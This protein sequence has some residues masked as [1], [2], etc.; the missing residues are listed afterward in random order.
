MIAIAFYLLKVIICS[1]ILYGY[2]HLA[3]KDKVFHQWNRFYLLSIVP[4]SI[5]LPLLNLHIIAPATDGSSMV[6]VMQI[7]AGADE[8]VA[9]RQAPMNPSIALSSILWLLYIAG[10][11]AVAAVFA[12]ALVSIRKMI[13]RNQQVNMGDFTFLNTRE[14]GTPFS[15]FRYLLWN[16]EIPLDSEN[17]RRILDHELIHIREHHSRDKLFILCVLVVGWMN[18][19]FWLIRRELGLIHEFIADQK[20]VGRGNAQALAKLLLE[21]SFPGYAPMMTN[22]FFTSSIKRRIAMMTKKQHPALNYLSRLMM[23]P[24][25]FVL[26]FAFGVKAETFLNENQ[27]TIHLDKPVTVVIDAGHGGTDDGAMFENVSEKN[28]TLAFAQV[29]KRLNNNP[30]LKLVFTRE[31]DVFHNV[32]EKV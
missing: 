18:P 11:A 12:K 3:L 30:N 32:K 28:I 10:S 25:L 22:P 8:Y 13:R 20:T 2:Y 29:I 17:G 6:T 7:V 21:T 27:P 14:P 19:F 26:L 1:G 15:Y 4:L 24:V 16:Q 9:E 31:S 5:L 23:I